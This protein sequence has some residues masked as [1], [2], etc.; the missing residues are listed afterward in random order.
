MKKPE[1]VQLEMLP[2]SNPRFCFIGD[3]SGQLYCVPVEYRKDFYTLL[4]AA[5]KTG[6]EKDREMFNNFV[7]PCIIRLPLHMYSFEKVAYELNP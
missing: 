4:S 3:D 5:I 7:R 1:Y 6:E 2:S